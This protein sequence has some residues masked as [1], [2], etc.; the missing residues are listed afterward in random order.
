MN[1]FYG[2][3]FLDGSDVNVAIDLNHQYDFA[4]GSIV[5]ITSESDAE[6]P[7]YKQIYINQNIAYIDNIA[8]S[9]EF[10][11]KPD[12]IIFIAIEEKTFLDYF[13][14]GSSYKNF[15]TASCIKQKY[16]I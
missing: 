7:M 16:D 15:I 3:M 5:I 12:E 10:I 2:K 9:I 14:C 1:R 11:T 4:Y 8:Y 6:A 13:L